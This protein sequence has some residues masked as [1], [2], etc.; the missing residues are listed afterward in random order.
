MLFVDPPGHVR[1]RRLVGKVFTAGRVQALRPRI[2]QISAGLLDRAGTEFDL[3]RDYAVPLPAMLIGELLG[4][5]ESDW[6][7][8]IEWS[9]TTIEGAALDPG[10]VVETATAFTGY[11]DE[12]CEARRATPRTTCS[13]PWCRPRTRPAC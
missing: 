10:E 7:Q 8:L 5:P 13:A 11:L 4:I 6:P 2:E 9:T 3:L 12:L 1:L